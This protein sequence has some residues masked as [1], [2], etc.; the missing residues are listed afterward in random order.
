M[1]FRLHREPRLRGHALPEVAYRR[2]ETIRSG[3]LQCLTSHR[4]QI[5]KCAARKAGTDFSEPAARFR[6]CGRLEL[7]HVQF[8]SAA[9]LGEIEIL[10]GISHYWMLVT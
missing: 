9:E 5:S 8:V 3:E 10:W 7:R 4:R 6:R 1:R 2:A